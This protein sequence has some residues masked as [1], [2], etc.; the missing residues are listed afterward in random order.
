MTFKSELEKLATLPAPKVSDL[1]DK[2]TSILW[3][4]P[5]RIKIKEGRNLRNV[6][7]PEIKEHI[8]DLGAD[9]MEHGMQHP[10]I[11]EFK[12]GEVLMVDG[13][14]RIRG[15]WYAL[16]QLGAE[17]ATVPCMIE[18]KGTTEGDR[19]AKMAKSY[20]GGKP[21]KPLELAKGVQRLLVGG[22]THENIAKRLGM[23]SQRIYQLVDLAMMPPEVKAAV[24]EGSISATAAAKIV[25]EEGA[26]EGAKTITAAVKEA[27]AEAK[28]G[29]G[30]GKVKTKHVAKSRAS[31]PT[32]VSSTAKEL[33]VKSKVAKQLIERIEVIK[34]AFL[35]GTAKEASGRVAVLWS[36]ADYDL[37][38]AKLGLK[39]AH[40]VDKEKGHDTAM[41]V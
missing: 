19:I 40:G 27:K 35:R 22:W 18:P 3:I 10:L 17:I 5:M 4:N 30:K 28:N 31:G 12:D 29:K 20:N 32:S 11:V 16:D 39:P 7:D 21:I 34:T 6:E 9:I 26:A 41:A 8:K 1:S 38:Q 33:A 15:V 14:C 23:T 36:K 25:H 13:E 37:L 2:R 24:Q